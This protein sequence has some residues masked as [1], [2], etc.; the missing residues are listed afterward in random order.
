MKKF[1]HGTTYEAMKEI[2]KGNYEPDHTIW[3]CSDDAK[4]YAW[5]RDWLA[6]LEC[7][8][9]DCTPGQI[10][11]NCAF[12]ANESGQIANALKKEPDKFTY[13]VEFAMEDKLYEEMKEDRRIEA[14]KSSPNMDGAVQ[15]EAFALNKYIKEGKANIRIFQFTFCRKL[16]L[17]Y[18][19]NLVDNDYFTEAL[20]RLEDSERQVLMALNKADTCSI[21]EILYDNTE[22]TKIFYPWEVA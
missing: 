11:T 8:D 12:R 19:M 2:I 16:A 15:I 6:G 20:E 14:D 1:Y 5:S 10:D 9:I 3:D 21:W 22:L 13:V 18:L 4:I 17:F 7:W